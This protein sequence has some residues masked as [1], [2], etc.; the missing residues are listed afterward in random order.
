ME[1]TTTASAGDDRADRAEAEK[2]LK[3]LDPTG[4]R[5]DAAVEEFHRK[6]DGLEREAAT[7]RNMMAMQRLFRLRAGL[8]EGEGKKD[9]GGCEVTARGEWQDSGVDVVAYQ[10]YRVRAAGTWTV[11]GGA[12]TTANGVAVKG[13]DIRLGQLTAD[14]K[15]KFYNLGEDVVFTP[16][17][18]GRVTFIGVD[19]KGASGRVQNR[20]TIYVIIEPVAR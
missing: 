5:I 13:S 12:E 4:N 15:D 14:I 16:Q 18:S 11:R 3:V 7:S 20:G 8:W 6:L 17:V 19:E 10:P 2:K 1:L 9:R